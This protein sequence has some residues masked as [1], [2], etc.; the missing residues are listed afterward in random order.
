MGVGHTVLRQIVGM[1]KVRNG[2]LGSLTREK[3]QTGSGHVVLTEA[4]VDGW[5][6]LLLPNV[7]Y[8]SNTIHVIFFF[9]KF[10]TELEKQSSNPRQKLNDSK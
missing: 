8:G 7:T 6:L 1:G 9:I 10:S 2:H 5:S 4:I 3:C